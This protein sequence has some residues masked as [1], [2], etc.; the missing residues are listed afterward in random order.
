MQVLKPLAVADVSAFGP[1]CVWSTLRT[2]PIIALK[3]QALL[4]FERERNGEQIDSNAIMLNLA[5]THVLRGRDSSFALNLE[6]VLLLR[7]QNA[8]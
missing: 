8:E 5:S 7:W 4:D 3:S 2:K 1:Q 6:I